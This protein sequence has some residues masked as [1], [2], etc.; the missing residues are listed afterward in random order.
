VLRALLRHLHRLHLLVIR[1]SVE[2]S[3]EEVLRSA[4]P[5]I[6]FKQ[7]DS[8]RRQLT[9]W[10]E[11]RL[12]PQLDRIAT[13]ELNTKTTGLPAETICREAMLAVARAARELSQ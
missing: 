7:Q 13:A 1:L 3:L 8:F 11:A 10:T 6:F 12:L 2:A 9:L 4:R 5:P